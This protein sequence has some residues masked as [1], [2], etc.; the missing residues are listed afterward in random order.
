MLPAFN[1]RYQWQ[2]H[3]AEVGGRYLVLV[4]YTD[5]NREPNIHN[6]WVY[7]SA[8]IDNSQVVWAR[9]PGEAGKRELLEYFRGR[10]VWIIDPDLQIA[11]PYP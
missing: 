10:K 11:E 8:D 3:F 5:H 2:E 7:N 9:E 6:E 1:T 4:R